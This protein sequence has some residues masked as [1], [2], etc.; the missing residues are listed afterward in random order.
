M[1]PS[2][3]ES[4]LRRWGYAYGE[5]RSAEWDEDRTLTGRHPLEI[6]Q[7]FAPGRRVDRR[8][9]EAWAPA[10]SAAMLKWAA[11]GFQ[12]R[13]PAWAAE[14]VPGK[15]SRTRGAAHAAEVRNVQPDLAEVE[16][17]AMAL[18]RHD[19]RRGVI[20]RL[21]YCKRG[22]HREKAEVAASALGEPVSVRVF[23]AELD[24]ARE[25]VRGRIAA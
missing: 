7:Q 9:P 13:P 11:N 2:E 8:T 23:R 20:L 10:R 18:Y 16:E 17:A 25:F 5:D 12:G 14:T 22:T 24:L 19:R 4:L 6:A 21:A 1:T 3:L 15:D